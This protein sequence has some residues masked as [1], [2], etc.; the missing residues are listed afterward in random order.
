MHVKVQCK[1]KGNGGRR[2]T[3]DLTQRSEIPWMEHTCY[4]EEGRYARSNC[5]PVSEM[6]RGCQE[7]PVVDYIRDYPEDPNPGDGIIMTIYHPLWGYYGACD[8]I[9]APPQEGM[10]NPRENYRCQDSDDLGQRTPNTTHYQ[11]CM[12]SGAPCVE[13]TY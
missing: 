10:L 6:W 2:C 3:L 9:T 8:K 13:G 1:T 12:P 5:K 7:P 4:D 11:I